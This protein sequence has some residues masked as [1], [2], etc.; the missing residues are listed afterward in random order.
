[1]GFDRLEPKNV[2]AGAAYTRSVQIDGLGRAR[3]ERNEAL[4]IRSPNNARA[5]R[6]R[7]GKEAALSFKPAEIS[8]VD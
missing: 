7:K 6:G 5:P 1:M 2:L 8:R 3:K 4:E